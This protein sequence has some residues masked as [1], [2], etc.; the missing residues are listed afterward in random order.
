MLSLVELRIVEYHGLLHE[1]L[2][3]QHNYTFVERVN[4]SDDQVAKNCENIP[5]SP[6][7]TN[8]ILQRIET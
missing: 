5:I 7:K 3:A 6:L 8:F 4:L 1:G 2:A